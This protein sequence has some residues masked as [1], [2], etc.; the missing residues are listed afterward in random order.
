MTACDF[1]KAGH[2]GRSKISESNSWT[3]STTGHLVKTCVPLPVLF[4]LVKPFEGFR[5]GMSCNKKASFGRYGQLVQVTLH[6]CVRGHRCAGGH[7]L[8]GTCHKTGLPHESPPSCF[9]QVPVLTAT[10][11]GMLFGAKTSVA[12]ACV[13]VSV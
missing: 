2:A 8:M 11:M 10:H 7:C 5:A 6:L 9:G 3:G 1:L 13:S 4:L 12:S